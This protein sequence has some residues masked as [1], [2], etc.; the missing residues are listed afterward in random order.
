MTSEQLRFRQIFESFL[1]YWD[2]WLK[3]VPLEPHWIS[4]TAR[5]RNGQ[6]LADLSDPHASFRASHRFRRA[7]MNDQRSGRTGNLSQ[8]FPDPFAAIPG[9]EV[10][11]DP[12]GDSSLV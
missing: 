3:S 1:R 9:S 10:R 6:E 5:S 12:G 4:S 2:A 7:Q 8:R 11:T